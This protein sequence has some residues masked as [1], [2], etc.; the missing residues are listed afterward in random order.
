MSICDD[1][2]DLTLFGDQEPLKLTGPH[3][4]IDGK[5]VLIR[6]SAFDLAGDRVKPPDAL[7]YR[8]VRAGK[9]FRQHTV[10][11]SN[12][13][14]LVGQCCLTRLNGGY[15]RPGLFRHG[16]NLFIVPRNLGGHCFS[17]RS[18]NL[19]V[20]AQWTD[21]HRSTRVRRFDNQVVADGHLYVSGMRKDE[22]ARPDL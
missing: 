21:P 3:R 6:G 22:I 14:M 7:T 4:G 2:R 15:R 19:N 12:R 17:Y 9:H 10:R 18:A 1:R 20:T 13:A 5:V 11:I 8:S 16:F